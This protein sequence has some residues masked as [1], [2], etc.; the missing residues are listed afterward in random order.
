VFVG[1]FVAAIGRQASAG[2]VKCAVASMLLIGLLSDRLGCFP[3]A[4]FGFDAALIH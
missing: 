2:I 3:A 1:V 4:F